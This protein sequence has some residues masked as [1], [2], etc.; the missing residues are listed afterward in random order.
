MCR[1]VSL[2][3]LVLPL[4]LYFFDIHMSMNLTTV[5]V[6]LTQNASTQMDLIIACALQNSLEMELY[7]L[8]VLLGLKGRLAN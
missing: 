7:A 3:T 2:L 1:L 4:V 8:Q 6:I 5:H